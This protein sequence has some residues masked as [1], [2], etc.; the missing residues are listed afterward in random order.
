MTGGFQALD[1]VDEDEADVELRDVLARPGAKLTYTYD[2]G[3]DWEH[4]V[5]LEKVISPDDPAVP[6]ILPA[7]LAGGGTCRQKTAA[8][9]P[10]TPPS[11]RPSPTLATRTTHTTWNG[12]A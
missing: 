9:R 10:A 3:D 8:A 2:F 6:E 1:S 5:K 7:V 11:S 12:W 4:E